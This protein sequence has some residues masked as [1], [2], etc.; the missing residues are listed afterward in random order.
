MGAMAAGGWSIGRLTPKRA[1]RARPV[2]V[3]ALEGGALEH[4]AVD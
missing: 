3:A 2:I 1:L 4:E